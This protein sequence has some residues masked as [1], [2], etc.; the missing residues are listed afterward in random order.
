MSAPE[1]LFAPIG[2]MGRSL[3]AAVRARTAGNVAVRPTADPARAA[4]PSATVGPGE[5]VCAASRRRCSSNRFSCNGAGNS[6][7]VL[8]VSRLPAASATAALTH[9]WFSASRVAASASW[10][11]ALPTRS[12]SIR[13]L[14]GLS[15][16]AAI[17]TP[18]AAI[19]DALA[20]FARD[21]VA[22]C[23]PAAALPRRRSRAAP[24][25]GRSTARSLRQ[26]VPTARTC[27]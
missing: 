12:V 18:R 25:G 13:L 22:G 27:T 16:D 3:S 21:P 15:P 5:R 26:R 1:G 9:S 24:T 19:S 11:T 4:R 14:R 8:L 10:H 23:N 20:V 7:G 17:C 2:K 6:A